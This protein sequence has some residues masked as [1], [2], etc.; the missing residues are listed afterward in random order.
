VSTKK[1]NLTE[2][3]VKEFAGYMLVEFGFK[4]V[5]KARKAQDP[6]HNGCGTD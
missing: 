4:A 1:P 2:T 3:L 5:E 6:S